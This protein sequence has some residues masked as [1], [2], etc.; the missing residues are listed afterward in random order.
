MFC[1][2]RRNSTT[3]VKKSWI[4]T[5][6]DNYVNYELAGMGCFNAND[7]AHFYAVDYDHH[8]NWKKNESLMRHWFVRQTKEN[9]FQGNFNCSLAVQV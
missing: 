7:L 9:L 5:H 6:S 4:E 3:K 1:K 8:H 2:K